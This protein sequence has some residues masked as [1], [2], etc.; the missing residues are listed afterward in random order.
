VIVL[1]PVMD[2]TFDSTDL[3]GTCMVRVTITD[4]IH[5]AHAKAGEHFELAPEMGAERKAEK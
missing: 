4:Q 5:S 2:I 1:N 3:P